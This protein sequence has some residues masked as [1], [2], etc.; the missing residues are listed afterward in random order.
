MNK[1]REAIC[2]FASVIKSGEPW[3]NRCQAICQDA[4]QQ[5]EDLL[6]YVERLEHG[7]A[8]GLSLEGEKRTLNRYGKPEWLQ[9]DAVSVAQNGGDDA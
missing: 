3:T 8:G 6:A 1:I 5:E 4:L 9:P 2:M 7:V